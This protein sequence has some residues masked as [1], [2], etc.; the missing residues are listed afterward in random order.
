M[1]VGRFDEVDSND[2]FIFKVFNFS[3]SIEATKEQ[4]VRTEIR[5]DM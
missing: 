2:T 4:I 1:V 5:F 3:E